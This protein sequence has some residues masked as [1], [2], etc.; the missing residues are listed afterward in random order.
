MVIFK[1]TNLSDTSTENKVIRSYTRCSKGLGQ[2]R[3]KVSQ[4]KSQSHR[5]A[6][7]CVCKV[8]SR[9]RYQNYDVAAAAAHKSSARSRRRRS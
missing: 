7:T 4:R 8:T 6:L 5:V 3:T 9:L 2:S 1:D